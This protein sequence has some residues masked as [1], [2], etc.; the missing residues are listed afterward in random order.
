MDFGTRLRPSVGLSDAA[1]DAG[2]LA[3]IHKQIARH[4][5]GRI[6][7]PDALRAPFGTSY[8]LA[9]EAAAA[10]LAAAGL[11]SAFLAPDAAASAGLAAAA[12]GLAS[13]AAKALVVAKAATVRAAR[14]LFIR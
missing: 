8:F 13:V 9:A 3:G 12:A 14:S 2:A 6:I 7:Q 5:A 1:S 4:E 11:V 10:G